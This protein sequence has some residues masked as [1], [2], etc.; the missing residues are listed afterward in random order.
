[1]T[2]GGRATRPPLS[3]HRM[4][5]GDSPSFVATQDECG[6]VAHTPLPQHSS[7]VGES[8]SFAPTQQQC[9]RVAHT[10]IALSRV[11]LNCR[12]CR[13][14][15]R[16]PRLAF[17]SDSVSKQMFKT[18]DPTHHADHHRPAQSRQDTQRNC[19]GRRMQPSR[20]SCR[21]ASAGTHSPPTELTL[22]ATL[23]STLTSVDASQTPSIPHS[24]RLS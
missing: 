23:T 7:N 8:P 22:T 1:M 10:P 4:N 5:V 20:T 19:Q 21:I 3:Q 11:A 6:R 18:N 13:A 9:G 2:K 17:D 15:R 24:P 14:V 16:Q 12:S